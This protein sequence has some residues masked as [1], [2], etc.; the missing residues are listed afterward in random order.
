MIVLVT[1]MVSTSGA[2]WSWFSSRSVTVISA[3]SP[4]VN[5][6]AEA[7]APSV[8]LTMQ[9]VPPIAGVETAA[10]VRPEAEV[11]DTELAIS[12]TPAGIG[13]LIVTSYVTMASLKGARS[14]I[15]EPPS[16]NG[17][18]VPP[19]SGNGAPPTV[20]VPGV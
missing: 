3:V 4:S 15:D 2:A 6:P 14:P 9:A 5:V 19:E 10:A 12:V 1:G 7:P 11:T 20:V 13:S 17:N 18:G 16:S 8:K